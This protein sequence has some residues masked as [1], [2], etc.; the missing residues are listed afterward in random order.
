MSPTS[1]STAPTGGGIAV[2]EP[3]PIPPSLL[4]AGYE[5]A[6]QRFYAVMVTAILTGT[7]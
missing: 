3:E 4:V 7:T 1:S 5:Q 6:C 2:V